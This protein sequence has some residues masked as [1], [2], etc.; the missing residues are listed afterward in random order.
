M[1]G[2]RGRIR[3]ISRSTAVCC[4][5]FVSAAISPVSA[6]TASAYAFCGQPLEANAFGRPIDYNNPADHEHHTIVERH[7]FSRE[8]EMLTH[9][10]TAESPVGDLAYVLRQIPN[11]YRARMSMST[12]QL[13]NGYQQDYE[14]SFIY[15]ADCY[16][17]RALNF[18]S[19]DPVLHL[20]YGIHLHRAGMLEQALT[21]Y[22]IAEKLGPPNAE[23]QYNLGLLNVDLK[24]YDAAR[25][26]AK[27]AYE[28]GYPL[29]GLKARLDRL[30]EW[31]AD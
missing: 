26:H 10:L 17:R 6:Q 31:A 12:F 20:I 15:T 23:L 14:F 27:K 3:S 24:R 19:E 8:V 22:E 2:D 7:H 16:F 21:E 30:G 18:T 5:F 9:G 28:L 25:E 13:K 4:A 1:V 11:H 29:H